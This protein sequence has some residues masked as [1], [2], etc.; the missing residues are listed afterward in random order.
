MDSKHTPGPW[1]ASPASG[2]VWD[3]AGTPVAV[4]SGLINGPANG[5]RGA[6]ACLIAAAPELLKALQA[7]LIDAEAAEVAA[8]M[9]GYPDIAAETKARINAARAA[10]AAA[11]GTPVEA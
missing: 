9:K 5:E 11:T 8:R 4:T 2:V 7:V 3:A 6:N 1:K 10:I